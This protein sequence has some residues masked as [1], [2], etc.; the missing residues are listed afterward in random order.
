MI[1]ILDNIPVLVL[2][3]HILSF[4]ILGDFGVLGPRVLSMYD[5]IGVS[6]FLVAQFK[7]IK[8]FLPSNA[9]HRTYNK[10]NDAYG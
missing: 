4:T 6:V 10:T 8:D 7:K 2:Y 9:E 5:F 3:T 1:I